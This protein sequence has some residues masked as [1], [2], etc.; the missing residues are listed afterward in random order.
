MCIKCLLP[1][2]LCSRYS[3]YGNEQYSKGSKR[4]AITELTLFSGGGGGAGQIYVNEQIR[5]MSDDD[6]G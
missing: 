6:K 2:S 5:S 4:S 1:A 3:E